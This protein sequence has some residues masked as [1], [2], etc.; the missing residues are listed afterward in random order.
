MSYHA[1]L[2]DK[3]TSE[4]IAHSN[5][6][7]RL[8]GECVVVLKNDGTLPIEEPSKLALY[9][10]GARHTIKGGTG[11]GDV[12]SRYVVNIEQ[13]LKDAGFEIT[14]GSWLDRYDEANTKHMDEYMAE[15]NRRAEQTGLPAAM[16]MFDYV[17]G[18]SPIP[19]V[20]P[21]DVKAADIAVYVL[22]RDSGEG[23]DRRAKKGDFYLSDDEEAALDV[24]TASFPR[25]VLVLNTGGIVSL[26]R[27]ADKFSAIL[28]L[29]QLGNL[30]GNIAADVITG[31]SDPSGRLSD[32][33][34]FDYAKYPNQE[35]FS[36]NNG[37]ADDEYYKEG[38]YIG[39]RYF[40]S[41]AVKP[42]YPFG[43]GL[44]YT[45]F[46]TKAVKVSVDGLN[47]NVEAQ[48]VNTGKRAGKE[49]VQLYVASPHEMLDKPYKELVAYSKSESL[50][51]GESG[52]IS[53]SFSLAQ[54]ASYCDGCESKVLEAG[55]YILL[56]GSNSEEV[57]AVAKFIVE[58]KI[59]TEKLRNVFGDSGITDEFRNPGLG[60]TIDTVGI[61]E[62]KI[63]AS[64][65][66]LYEAKYVDD[67]QEL[68]DD[69]SSDTI[70]F[71]DILAGKA[72]V[73]ELVAQLTVEQMAKLCV[74]DYGADMVQTSNVVGSASTQV[75]G[76]AA[77][78][79][80]TY[81]ESRGIPSMILADGPAGLRL[82]PHFK[83]TADGIKLPGGE[84]FGLS[85]N[86]FPENIPED[87]IDYYQYC[88]AIPIATALA[89]SFNLDL[90][91]RMGEIVGEEM[92]E[93]YVH[94]WLAPGMNIHR[95]PLC[96]RNFEYYSEDPLISGKCA[97]A[98][99]KGVQ[100][101]GGQGT[102]IKHFCC[103]NQEVNRM[104][105]NSHASERTIRNLYLRGFEIAV[106][107]SQPYSVMSS[108]NLLNGTHTANHVGLCRNVLR[109]EW[110]FQGVVMTDWYTS[111]ENVFGDYTNAKY[112]VSSS[113]ECI[114]SGNDWQMPGCEANVTDII[115]AV[116]AGELPKADLQFCT[117]NII[118]MAV[119]CFSDGRSI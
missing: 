113:V 24:I 50:K 54:I 45:T 97:A 17:P 98:M 47:V 23:G 28:L 7:R 86:P 19:Q 4:E 82:Q 3:I 112:P 74:G 22:S 58:D 43:F 108:Y 89:Q 21:E 25:S 91:S 115:N 55:D 78:T 118:K 27:Y 2:T 61:P 8:A 100:S 94:F 30:T 46:E 99:T 87:A 68:T 63:D 66:E 5:E 62:Y 77:E 14:T 42:D 64:K 36:I 11:S 71:E 44:G 29:S 20:S 81:E 65:V 90:I 41:F 73:E 92:K 114:R 40:D 88:T 95:N 33:W 84:V 57:T 104:F 39:Y 70:R 110:G 52:T 9:G 51:P 49:V 72:T 105:S 79:I 119:K 1:R 69:R 35:G 76:A 31:K 106:K 109:D 96:G 75:P 83:T 102:T 117:C 85:Y 12:N 13:G 48:T 38:V 116:E 111:Q 56:A 101:L 37:N 32:S 103:N 16:I 34:C 6:V 67:R 60:A 80:T 15:V 10:N 93:Y 59:K 53:M 107:E 26:G 18:V